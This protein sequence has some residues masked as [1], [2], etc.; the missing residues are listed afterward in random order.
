MDEV[1][2]NESPVKTKAEDGKA[3]ELRLEC[4]KI[5]ATGVFANQPFEVVIERA[6]RFEGFVLDGRAEGRNNQQWARGGE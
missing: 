2:L 3:H 6:K 5:A 4:L 1:R